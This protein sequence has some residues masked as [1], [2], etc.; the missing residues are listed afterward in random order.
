MIIISG[1]ELKPIAELDIN[2]PKLRGVCKEHNFNYRLIVGKLIKSIYFIPINYLWAPERIFRVCDYCDSFYEEIPPR[3]EKVL[4]DFYHQK[5]TS[6]DMENQIDGFL[7]EDEEKLK[8]D[9]KKEEDHFKFFIKY[10]P[11]ILGILLLLVIFK[12]IFF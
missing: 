8:V 11:Y 10:V 3:Y 1:W 5:I 12:F 7:N 2:F 9:M 4:L 6:K